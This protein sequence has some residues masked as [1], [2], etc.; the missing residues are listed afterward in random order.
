MCLLQE[1]C[2]VFAS[3]VASRPERNAPQ[4]ACTNAVGDA[5][6]VT[7][8]KTLHESAFTAVRVR[9]TRVPNLLQQLAPTARTQHDPRP[10]SLHSAHYKTRRKPTQMHNN[11]VTAR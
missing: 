7:E 2:L 5:H 9:S 3:A 6:R 10:T 1:A 11:A 4:C 8:K